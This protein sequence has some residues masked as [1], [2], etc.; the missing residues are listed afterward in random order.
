MPRKG[1]NIYKRSDGRWE[2]RYIKSR[3]CTG[4]IVYGYVYAKTYHEVKAKLRENTLLHNQQPAVTTSYLFSAVASDWFES[5]K[6]QTKESTQ[7]KYH[8]M[9][10]DYIL[11]AY[12]EQTLKNITYEF[13]ES[14]CNLLLA[15]GGKNGRGLSAKTVSDVLSVIRSVLKF[16]MKKGMYVPCDGSAIQIKHTPKPMRVLSRTEQKQLCKYILEEPELK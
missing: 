2:G 6:S 3:T 12:G 13:I 14:H 10:H 16:A 15:S 8:N 5:V 7:N 4:K 11:P 1:E 9:L